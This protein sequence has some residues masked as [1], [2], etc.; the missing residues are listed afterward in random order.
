L[1]D[2][3]G[4]VAQNLR[5]IDQTQLALSETE[6]LYAIISKLNAAQDY[7]TILG[8]V[9]EF[10]ILN[11]AN[12]S[13]V[14]CTFD[15]MFGR[16]QVPDWAIPISYRSRHDIQIASRYPISAFEVKQNTLFTNQPVILEEV[17]LDS[18]LDRITRTLFKDVFKAQSAI[19]VPLML[20]DQSIGFIL[21]SYGESTHFE[22]AQIQR[23]ATVANQVAVAV[24]GMQLLRQTVARAH[25]EQLMLE[26][27]AQINRSVD[28]D[29]IM[30][31]A[32]EALGKALHKQAYVVLG[33]SEIQH[34]EQPSEVPPETDQ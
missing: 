31:T 25:R 10:T 22:E 8:A 30:R 27:T 29:S 9:A 33:G 12:Q 24:Q 15:R 2:Q 7:D 17:A 4:T 11:Q 34:T 14:M 21:G 5:L 16:G 26:I 20:G 32:V 28:T 23:L 6:A 1:I 18:R 3:A 19:I 13:L